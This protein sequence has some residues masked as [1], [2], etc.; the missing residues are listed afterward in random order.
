MVGARGWTRPQPSSPF[1]EMPEASAR[2][3]RLGGWLLATGDWRGEYLQLR[4][5]KRMELDGRPVFLVHAAPEN[6]RQR[7]VYL[8]AENGLT[9]GYDEV[10]DMRGLAM[11]GCEIRFADYR[12]IEGVQIP[13]KTTVKYMHPKLGTWTY[14]VE[15]I[16]TGV[17]LDKDPFKVE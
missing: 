3:A 5:L 13:F 10:H 11:I 7:L 1:K 4:V 14:Q 16:E 17:K 2:S 12:D 6:G 9:L 8:D 15:K